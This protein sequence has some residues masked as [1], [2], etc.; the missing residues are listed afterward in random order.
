ML[1][2]C[3]VQAAMGMRRC[4]LAKFCDQLPKTTLFSNCSVDKSFSFSKRKSNFIRITGW[5]WYEIIFTNIPMKKAIG[6]CIQIGYIDQTYIAN[7]SKRSFGMFP[8]IAIFESLFI[9]DQKYPMCHFEK[10][11]LENCPFQFKPAVLRRF[12]DNKFF[13]FFFT[14]T[15]CVLRKIKNFLLDP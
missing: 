13:L 14:Y 8:E 4:N 10:I 2:F 3:P 6:L 9:P 15:Y 1:P 11:R 12:V 7:L 5:F